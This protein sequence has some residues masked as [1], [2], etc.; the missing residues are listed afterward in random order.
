M[1]KKDPAL[2]P[3]PPSPM[4]MRLSPVAGVSLFA[5]ML[6]GLVACL[7]AMFSGKVDLWPEHLGWEGVRDGEITHHIAHELS[8]VSLAK[9]AADLE[10]AFSWLTVGDTGPRVRSGCPGWLFLADETR[11][12]PHAQA[13]AEAR[14]KK[15][16]AV[17]DWLAARNIR[18]LVL[19][20][21]DKSR[22]AAEQLCGI[23]RA[24]SLAGRL[25]QWNARLQQ[26]GIVTVDP[27][28]ALQALGSSAF[29]RTDTHWSEQGAEAAARQLAAAVLASGISPSPAQAS[30]RTLLPEA[31]RPGDLVRLAG[32]DWLPERLQ[33]A[34]EMVAA[35]RFEVQGDATAG[36]EADLFGDSQ[37]PNIALI[38]T[39]FSRNSNF[40]PFL[41]QGIG[42]SVGNFAKDGGEFSGAGKDYFASEA[43]KQTPAQLLIWEINERDLQKP[44]SDDMPLR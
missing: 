40:V 27:T 32:L 41:E 34:G 37:L 3:V 29:L 17:R 6:A 38:G 1:S 8:N 2:E 28:S 18:L 4:M 43:F 22:I 33:P 15:V 39:S 7:W 42:A 12:Y 21:P 26:A 10:R 13:N 5:F 9:R 19:L 35:S 25:Q 44:F 16:M 23:T 30:V 31:R 20:V 36:S 11:L 24:L 14:A